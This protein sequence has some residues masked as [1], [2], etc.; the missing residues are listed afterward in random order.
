MWY[1]PVSC[2]THTLECHIN[3]KI[4]L[5]WDGALANAQCLQPRHH[6][7]HLSTTIHFF[8]CKLF[9]MKCALII[10]FVISSGT[11]CNNFTYRLMLSQL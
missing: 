10:M 9:A 5:Y 7:I 4:T 1:L 11:N 6:L 3:I 2:N 8:T